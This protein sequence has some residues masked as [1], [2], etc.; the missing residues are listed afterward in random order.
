[1]SLHLLFK[2]PNRSTNVFTQYVSPV[3]P[4][5]KY[6]LAIHSEIDN[7][8][9]FY[10]THFNHHFNVHKDASFTGYLS[11][12]DFLDNEI[13]FTISLVSDWSFNWVC[14]LGTNWLSNS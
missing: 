4:S 12:P 3:T 11:S 5:F 9:S 1:M 6:F 8:T 10:S 14:N 2:L 7:K 13:S